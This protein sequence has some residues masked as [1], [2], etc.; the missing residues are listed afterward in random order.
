MLLRTISW[1]IL[2]LPS[3]FLKYSSGELI[4]DA[5]ECAFIGKIAITFVLLK[6]FF[7]RTASPCL[8]CHRFHA[9]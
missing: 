4:S 5:Q 3:L 7:R 6:L 2:V 9:F 1:F 8:L